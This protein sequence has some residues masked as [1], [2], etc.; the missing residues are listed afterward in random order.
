MQVGEQQQRK[1]YD[2]ICDLHIED[3]VNHMQNT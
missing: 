2:W 1:E 3:A